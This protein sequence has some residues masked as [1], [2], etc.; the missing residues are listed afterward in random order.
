M[1]HMCMSV[2]A[3]QK[4]AAALMNEMAHGKGILLH[5]GSLGTIIN[6]EIALPWSALVYW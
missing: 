5:N 1:H 3:A 6:S 4:A 2:E